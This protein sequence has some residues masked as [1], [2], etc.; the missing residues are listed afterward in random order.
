MRKTYAEIELHAQP[1]NELKGK[2][3][4]HMLAGAMDQLVGISRLSEDMQ[5]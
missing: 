5:T 4:G 2:R 3:D 1:Y